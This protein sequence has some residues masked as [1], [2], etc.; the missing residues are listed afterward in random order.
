[1]SERDC[2]FD[3]RDIFQFGDHIRVDNA[4]D[5]DGIFIALRGNQLIWV[6]YDNAAGELRLVYSPFDEVTVQRLP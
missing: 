3:F 2:G 6:R 4:V 5:D 1:M